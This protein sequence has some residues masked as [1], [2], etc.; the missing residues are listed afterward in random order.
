[1]KILKYSSD[2]I[3]DLSSNSSIIEKITIDA[4][5]F[6]SISRLPNVFKYFLSHHPNVDMSLKF[7]PVDEIHE[8][9]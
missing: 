8:Q 7:G 1:M 4:N 2:A 3:S 5:E 9:L 6:F